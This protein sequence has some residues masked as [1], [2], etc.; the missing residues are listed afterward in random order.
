MVPMAPI[1]RNPPGLMVGTVYAKP[2]KNRI[3]INNNWGYRVG[4]APE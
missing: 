4:S 3:N 2:V 1:N